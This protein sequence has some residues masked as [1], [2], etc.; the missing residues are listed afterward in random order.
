M[1]DSYTSNGSKHTSDRLAHHVS[2]LD[3]LMPRQTTTVLTGTE[4]LSDLLKMFQYLKTNLREQK[5]G[6]SPFLKNDLQAL[7]YA[8]RVA[9]Y[10]MQDYPRQ[11][12][13]LPII[14]TLWDALHRIRR[15]VSAWRTQDQAGN[16]QTELAV[17]ERIVENALREHTQKDSS[18][19]SV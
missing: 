11:V 5:T 6:K 4:I 9:T 14:T 8:E 10:A 3:D 2:L 13:G 1:S 7:L 15:I 19:A 17:I 16:G 18:E 12:E